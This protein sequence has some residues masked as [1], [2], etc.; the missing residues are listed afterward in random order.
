MCVRLNKDIQTKNLEQAG[1]K[2]V[3]TKENDLRLTT[4]ISGAVLDLFSLFL[5]FILIRV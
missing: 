1:L 3:P 4:L 2:Y 5:I